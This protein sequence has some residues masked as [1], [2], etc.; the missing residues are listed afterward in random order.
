[1]LK[2]F[3][4]NQVVLIILISL[5]QCLRNQ[6]LFNVALSY[7][8]GE[9]IARMDADDESLPE[10]LEKQLAYLNAR[11]NMDVIAVFTSSGFSL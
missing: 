7:A 10:R 5:N 9:Y 8:S 11:F 3:P 1:M 4:L 2:S 6:V